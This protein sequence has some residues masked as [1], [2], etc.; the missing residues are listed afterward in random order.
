MAQNDLGKI[1]FTPKGAYNDNYT[2]GYLDVFTYN[3]SSYAVLQSAQGITPPNS[4]YYQILSEKGVDG[5][6]GLAAVVSVGSVSSLPV[7]STP[8][9]TNTGTDTNAILNFGIPMSAMDASI[10]ADEYDS[11]KDYIVG[12]YCTYNGV[13]YRF[14]SNKTAGSWDSGSVV[15]VAIANDVQDCR[16]DINNMCNI[17]IGVNICDQSRCAVGTLNS[18]G[19]IDSTS[20]LYKTSDYVPVTA[21]TTYTY[22]IFRNNGAIATSRKYVACYDASRS[23]ISGSYQNVNGESAVTIQSGSAAYIRVSCTATNDIMVVAGSET[24]SSYIAYTKTYVNTME[25]DYSTFAQ[26]SDINLYNSSS[27]VQGLLKYNGEIQESS[28]YMTTDY[29]PVK[30][31]MSYLISPRCRYIVYYNTANGVLSYDSTEHTSPYLATVSQDGFIRISYNIQYPLTSVCSV[32]NGTPTKKIQEGVSLSNTQLEEVKNA[33]MF[34]SILTGKKW[35]VCGDSF[36]NGG[37]TGTVIESGKYAGENY[38]YPWIIGNRCDMEIAQFFD[39]GRTLAFPAIPD[40]FTN[41]LTNP[42]A[43]WYYQNIPADVD[44]ITIYLGINDEH[45]S[46]G[47]SGGDG[48]DNTG[49]IPIGTLSDNT[50]T[51]YLGAWN[52]VLTWLISNRPNAHIGIIVTNGIA[53]N[54]QYRQGQIAIAQK[55]GIPYI[56]LNGDARTPAMLRTS[57]PNISSTVKQIL[58]GKWAVSQSNQHPNDAAQL[59]ES[60]F[61]QAFLESI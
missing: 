33:A 17:V 34:S 28:T 26:I 54:D 60:S 46:S 22:V 12:D 32:Y 11:T 35:A 49:I 21:N 25:F 58:I 39:G 19:T 61:I 41:S 2:Y 47:G 6:D 15:S 27:D 40:T 8:T 48:E 7:G 29:I 50:T 51:T 1:S 18:D 56:D 42:N 55:Y 10:V 9:V 57:N 37:G 3:G 30:Y 24:P 4:T 23:F 20:T 44:Y 14:V 36:T 59:F 16:Y 38:T 53:N 45:H 5:S 52:V 31:G 13:L 43:D